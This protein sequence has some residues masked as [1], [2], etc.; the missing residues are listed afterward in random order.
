MKKAVSTLADVSFHSGANI[1]R[2]QEIPSQAGND[3]ENGFSH[4]QKIQKPTQVIVSI[5]TNYIKK[6]CLSDNK[7]NTL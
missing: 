7:A 6:K 2:S 3:I 5:I 1:N 4:Q